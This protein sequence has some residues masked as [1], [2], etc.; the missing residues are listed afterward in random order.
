VFKGTL[1]VVDKAVP[2]VPFWKG[3]PEASGVGTTLPEAAELLVPFD[4]TRKA[5]HMLTVLLPETNWPVS[6]FR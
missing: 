2:A 1:D 3:A 5:E 4:I 6:P